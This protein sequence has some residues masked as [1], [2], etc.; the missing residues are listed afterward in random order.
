MKWLDQLLC[1]HDW[2]GWTILASR[3]DDFLD[4][5]WVSK[6]RNCPKCRKIQ[7]TWSAN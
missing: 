6:V 4:M 1:E 5:G 3:H 7:T 2:T